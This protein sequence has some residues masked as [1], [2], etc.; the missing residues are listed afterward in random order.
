[1]KAPE[2]LF[3]I[4]NPTVALMLR[5]PWHGIVSSSICLIEYKGVKTG[6]RRRVPARYLRDGNIVW[7]N[8]SA[9]T[10]WWRNFRS[11][12]PV[13]ITLQRRSYR[14]ISQAIWASPEEFGSVLTRF[15]DA[16]PADAGYHGITRDR[17]GNWNKDEYNAACD[18][19]VAIRITLDNT[20][21]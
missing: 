10:G 8:T 5:S 1:M 18:E 20:D 9:E 15:L 11:P 17:D 21:V 16:F 14:A 4:I 6:Q 7:C 12:H 3:S 19:G 2:F 13:T